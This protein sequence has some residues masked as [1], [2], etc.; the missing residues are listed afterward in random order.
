MTTKESSPK[1]G[2]LD[3]FRVA[4]A[5]LVVAIHTSPL[6]DVSAGADFFLTRILARTA[7][8]FF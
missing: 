4:A 5:A 2:G 8:P 1:L 6:A 7:V 3:I